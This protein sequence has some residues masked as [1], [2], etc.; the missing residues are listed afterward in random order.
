MRTFRSLGRR[1]D[2]VLPVIGGRASAIKVMKNAVN[3]NCSLK[4]SQKYR[5]TG[6]SV[7]TA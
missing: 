1:P 5:L 2:V 6:P 7:T 3:N 4:L